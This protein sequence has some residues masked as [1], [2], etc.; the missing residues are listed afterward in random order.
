MKKPIAVIITTLFLISCAGTKNQ[1]NNHG[2]TV[3]EQVPDFTDLTFR[4]KS[5]AGV[6]VLGSGSGA[7]ITIRGR[8]SLTS[9][10]EPLYVFN[11]TVVN[12][13]SVLYNLAIPSKI[14]EIEVLKTPDETS[15]WGSR[16]ANG[17]I[18][19]HVPE[20]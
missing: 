18:I 20:G 19:V 11:E 16:G 8:T 15:P 17:V 1:T 2:D 9:A 7:Q 13:Y 10:I 4:L 5:R 14:A 6:R 12:S 3:E